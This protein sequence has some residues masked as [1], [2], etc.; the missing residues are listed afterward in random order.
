MDKMPQM[1]IMTYIGQIMIVVVIYTSLYVQGKRGGV[2]KIQGRCLVERAIVE[3]GGK[4]KYKIYNDS[5]LK[6]IRIDKEILAIEML[7][8]KV[9][10]VMGL[11]R[12]K[13]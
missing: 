8:N 9:K 7:K 5:I 6:N 10:I 13:K 1:E 11:Y 4:S 2:E 3:I 12:W